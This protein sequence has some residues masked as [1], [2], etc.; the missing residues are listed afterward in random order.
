MKNSPFIVC[1]IF[2]VLCIQFA[3]AQ[4]VNAHMLLTKINDAYTSTD[5]IDLAIKFT[6]YKGYQGNEITEEYDGT[7]Y[8]SS[9]VNHVNILNAE[10]LNV[11]EMRLVID[12]ENRTI[13]CSKNSDFT[14]KGSPIDVTTLVK[15]Y[16]IK[17]SSLRGN[18]QIVELIAKEQ[19]A[20]PYTK[21]VL[22]I[23]LETNFLE[24]QE[25]FFSNKIP[26]VDAN[27]KQTFNEARM[28]VSYRN[29][30]N[31]ATKIYDLHDYILIPAMA[32]EDIKPTQKY[33]DY[34]II[35]STNL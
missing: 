21:I 8:K 1:S 4:E 30:K 14:L 29:M 2:L 35:D 11:P 25:L 34:K 7:Y 10:V 33:N 23:N 15:Y 17:T 27:G 32:F 3:K 31:T 28:M 26:F 24:R 13:E 20:L 16:K 9:T 5:T 12:H 19:A 18:T 6:M 22:H